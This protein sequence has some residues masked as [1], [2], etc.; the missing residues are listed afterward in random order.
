MKAQQQLHPILAGGICHH[1]IGNLIIYNIIVMIPTLIL[2][3]LYWGTGDERRIYAAEGIHQTIETVPL[4]PV[5]DER[6]P[7]GR[8]R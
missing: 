6:Q 1:E 2:A 4:Y 7:E 8:A 5:G 3:V